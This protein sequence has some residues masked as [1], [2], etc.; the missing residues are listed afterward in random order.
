MKT[1]KDTA[2]AI[3]TPVSID[4]K[5]MAELGLLARINHEI[6]HPLGYSAFYV[7]DTG[8]SPG[9]LVSESGGWEFTPEQLMK[10]SSLPPP[11]DTLWRLLTNGYSYEYIQQLNEESAGEARLLIDRAIRNWRQICEEVS[12]TIGGEDD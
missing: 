11:S 2:K 7:V 9:A 5:V 1:S 4:W 12:A 8:V 6:L 10:S 3:E